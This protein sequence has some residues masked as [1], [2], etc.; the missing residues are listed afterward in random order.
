MTPRKS[1]EKAITPAT[2]DVSAASIQ[3]LD[4]SELRDV[5]GGTLL[6]SAVSE[7]MKN[8]GQALQ[9]AARGG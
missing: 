5:S 2:T 1:P 4:E 9:T 3:P 6:S 8:F 7:V